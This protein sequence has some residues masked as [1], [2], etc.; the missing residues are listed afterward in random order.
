MRPQSDALSRRTTGGERATRGLAAWLPGACAGALL[1][2]SAAPALAQEPPPPGPAEV[3]EH[4]DVTGS[5]LTPPT[6][7]SG[8]AWLPRATP[9]YGVHRPWRGWDVRLDGSLM[10]QGIYEPGD[11][12]R[13]GGAATSQSGSLNW[14]MAM[15]RRRVGNGRLGLRTM[16]S[17]EPW[18]V[19]DC[20]SLNFLA[21]G[22]VCAGDTIHDRQQPHDLV[23]ELA[24][25]VDHLL[26]GAWRWQAYAGLAGEPAL[27]PTGYPHRPSAMTNPIAP[28]THHWLDAT[29]TAFGVLTAGVHNQRVKIEGSIFNARS[30]DESRTD[31]DL[32]RFDSGAVRISYLPTDR[33]AI[34]TS[35]GRVTDPRLVF[36]RQPD[37]AATMGTASATYVRPRG[38]GGFLA[39]TAGVGVTAARQLVSGR[40]FERPTVGALL[41][42]TAM[43]ADRHAL[44]GRA[45]LATM[46]GH[47]L[48]ATEYGRV[49]FQVGKL[50]T[51]YVRQFRSRFGL[52]PGLGAAIALSV[53][54]EALAPRYSSRGVPSLVLF[55]LVRPIRH[56]M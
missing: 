38:D 3:H 29:H 24:L 40:R 50:E 25:D 13:T 53:V 39:V 52:A 35:V 23:M 16:L 30:P 21:T 37:P 46:P 7:V 26:A 42:A 36:E 45:E 2:A 12:H 19:S 6:D 27:G 41:E 55:L 14:V 4:V 22:E 49:V 10:V 5:L 56:A 17:A 11:R 15:A 20:G 43:L 8:T 32:G 54:P 44:F 48:H 1:I 28:M 51:G 9:M 18:T 34:Q 33:L 31:L 47:M